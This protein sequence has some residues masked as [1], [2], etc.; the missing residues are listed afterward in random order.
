[1]TK[2]F[3]ALIF[4]LSTFLLTSVAIAQTGQEEIAKKYGIT[5]P[6][7]ELGNCNSILN[8]E[9]FCDKEENQQVCT[10]FAKTKGLHQESTLVSDEDKFL[11]LAQK[12]LGCK[13]QDECMAFCDAKDNWRICAD[14]AKRNGLDGG[15]VA[16]M[17]EAM[18]Q[19]GCNSPKSC[20]DYCSNPLN[21]PKCM[22]TFKNAG[23]AVG[24]AEPIEQWCPKQARGPQ[25]SCVIEG[26]NTC[27]CTDSAAGSSP[28]E[29]CDQ[30]GGTWKDEICWFGDGG[31]F[32]PIEVW[33]P[34]QGSDCKIE[35][36]TCVCG[37]S[38]ESWCPQI[39]PDCRVEDGQ[40]TCGPT[41]Q[42]SPDELESIQEF[43][44][45]QGSS[46]RVEGEICICDGPENSTPTYGTPVYETPTYQT[47]S[48]EYPTPSYPTPYYDMPGYTT[49]VYPS[50]ES[51]STIQG[52]KT[53]RGLLPLILDQISSFL[54]KL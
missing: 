7:K 16:Q 36:D 49:P 53:T 45:K 34:K 4:F 13:S 22:Q 37:G 47:P 42:G 19:L 30:D 2:I 35:R 48:G 8:C 24:S 21:M 29:W 9:A 46:C 31:T 40:C 12:E 6:V 17:E 10:D 14:F 32:E 41:S 25:E 52:V 38:I 43:C 20:M 28:K 26:G 39:G 1:M 44:A 18:Q 51:Y 11:K 33:C 3:L 15:G 54:S 50:P 27:I 5:F 23:F